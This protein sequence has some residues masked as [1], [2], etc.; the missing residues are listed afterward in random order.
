M[1]FSLQDLL[2]LLGAAASG[3]VSGGGFGSGFNSPWIG[4]GIGAVGC[5][6]LGKAFSPDIPDGG[7]AYENLAQKQSKLDSLEYMDE[8]QLKTISMSGDQDERNRANGILK[9]RKGQSDLAAL[10]KRND[11]ASTAKL[12]TYNEDVARLRAFAD[13]AMR[14][15]ADPAFLD[16]LNAQTD[17]EANKGYT[18]LKQ[19]FLGR[20]L[21][22]STALGTS[23]K[24]FAESVNRTKTANAFDAE[25]IADNRNTTTLNA[26]QA[27]IAGMKGGMDFGT[28]KDNIGIAIKSGENQYNT[29]LDAMMRAVGLNLGNQGVQA[30]LNTDAIGYNTAN[31]QYGQNNAILAALL[32]EAQRNEKKKDDKQPT[33]IDLYMQD[34]F[35]V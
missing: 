34:R 15:K 31:T 26:L 22:Q 2:P 1:G 29:S 3:Y 16:S 33:G 9:T 6:F 8:G 14:I 11:D 23:L 28:A 30:G 27:A 24:E 19:Q 13:P 4:A 20:G 32:M 5:N 7:K 35:P 25:K 12:N 21:G 17:V 18:K 10:A